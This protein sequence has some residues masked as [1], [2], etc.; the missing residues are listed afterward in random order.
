MPRRESCNAFDFLPISL[1]ITLLALVML[2]ASALGARPLS[3]VVVQDSTVYAAPQLFEIYQ[4]H[5]GKPVSV[6]TA[7]A[8]AE[9]LQQ[10]YLADGYSRPGF[11][12]RDTGVR[13]GIARIQMVE[14]RIS[15]VEF[16]GNAG[17]WREQ[18]ESLVGGLDSQETLR[19]DD[20][21]NALRRAR[22]LPGLA[23]NVTTQPDEQSHGAYVLA[24]DSAYKP[25]EGRVTLSNRG[26]REIGRNLLMARLTSNGLFG[27][28]NSTGL[29]ATTAEDSEEY[30]GGGIF[31]T[32]TFGERGASLQLQGA[33]T[34][35]SI[36]TQGIPVQ[37]RRERILARYAHPLQSL[38]D[39]ELVLSVGADVENLDVVQATITTREERLRSLQAGL[40]VTWRGGSR[41]QLMGLDIEQ[42]VNGFGSRLDNFL[43]ADDPRQPDFTIARFRYIHVYRL[44][45]AWLLRWDA[46]AQ[47]STDVLPSIKRFRVGGG[48]IGR[49][50]EAAAASGDRG[51]GNKLEL[52]RRIAQS[53]TWVERA[54]LY[55]YFDLGTT[56]RNDVT[57]RESASSGGFGLSLSTKHLSTYLEFAKPLTHADVDNSD[58]IG[59]FG[60]ITVLF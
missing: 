33:I 38:A 27:S 54:D 25:L 32:T 53:A 36:E 14:A 41:Q 18:L 29:F 24:V 37:Q 13:S 4:Q 1:V 22:E 7:R 47:H 56:W 6:D 44:S 60:E 2:P 46:L 52:K 21:R 49:G 50:F 45:E 10:R 28:E 43:V 12:V 39:R 11:A 23:V 55:G 19:P 42:G 34:S 20:V 59:V 16:T 15:H 35:L 57:N 26:T 9:T 58:D 8:I 30:R 31:S 17:P 40:A 5:L 3:S 48:R 51:V